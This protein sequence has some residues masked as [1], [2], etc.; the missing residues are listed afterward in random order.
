MQTS[1]RCRLSKLFFN[2]VI[3]FRRDHLRAKA[4]GRIRRKYGSEFASFHFSPRV[5]VNF[6]VIS[7]KLVP[8]T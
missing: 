2:Y 7:L 3:A 6:K 4:T 5:T 8:L 1:K